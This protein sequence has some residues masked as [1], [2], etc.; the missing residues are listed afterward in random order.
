[1][2]SLTIKDLSH[3]AELSVKALS[4]VRGGS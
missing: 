1:M 4:E 2:A 3:N